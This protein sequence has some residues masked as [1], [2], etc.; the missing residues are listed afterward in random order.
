[1]LQ[2]FSSSKIKLNIDGLAK[3]KKR[4]GVVLAG[5]DL[6]EGEGNKNNEIKRNGSKQMGTGIPRGSR[7]LSSRESRQ[8]N[9]D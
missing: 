5:K 6:G 9:G 4:G 2:V 1:M 8:Y 3:K 7:E